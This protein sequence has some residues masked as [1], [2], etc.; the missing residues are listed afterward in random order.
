LTV[1]LLLPTSSVT[2]RD[3]VDCLIGW[4]GAGILGVAATG[5][6]AMCDPEGRCEVVDVWVKADIGRFLVRR[7]KE[8]LSVLLNADI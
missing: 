2:A 3:G 7:R 6:G 1:G 5:A 8:G 4:E